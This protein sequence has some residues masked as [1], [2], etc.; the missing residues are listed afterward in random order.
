MFQNQSNSH[1]ESK[2]IIG[3]V[4]SWIADYRS[5][6]ESIFKT[7]F[8]NLQKKVAD[9]RIQSITRERNGTVFINVSA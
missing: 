8:L 7:S 1:L 2:S 5:Y 4:Y 6:L 3:L 9:G